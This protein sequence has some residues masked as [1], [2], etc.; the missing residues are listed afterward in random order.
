VPNEETE[1]VEALRRG[2]E[3]AFEA[4]VEQHH[5]AMGRVALIYTGDE[6]LA[7]EA[8]QETWIGVL[9]GL[10][11]F[12]GRSSLKTWIFSILINRAK[13]I[14]ERE[15]RHVPLAMDELDEAGPSVP[16]ERFKPDD[17][18]RWPRH[19][20]EDPPSWNNIP[21]DRLLSEETLAHIEQAIAALPASQR[22]VIT[23]R[24]IEQ[25]SAEEVCNI[26]DLSQ[27]NQRVLLH[28]ARSRVRA[29]LETYFAEK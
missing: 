18:P 5:A 19:W 29:A 20:L 7:E 2:D 13:S 22:E 21:E 3:R 27:T 6:R 11:R 17:D 24:D 12:E 10:D 15:G 23:L 25:W 28:R 14:G 4:L 8:I 26:L 16:R 9:R 1:L